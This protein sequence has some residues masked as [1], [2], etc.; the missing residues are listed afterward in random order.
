MEHPVETAY[1]L[2][3]RAKE[4]YVDTLDR[5]NGAGLEDMFGEDEDTDLVDEEISKSILNNGFTNG[6]ER[7]GYNDDEDTDEIESSIYDSIMAYRF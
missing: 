1:T 2:M 4:E 5:I 3:Q 7:Y 6:T